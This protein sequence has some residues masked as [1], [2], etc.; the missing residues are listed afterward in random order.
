MRAIA[1]P[2]TH[3]KR[4]HL[5]RRIDECEV[6]APHKISDYDKVT[7]SFERNLSIDN[8]EMDIKHGNISIAF[9]MTMCT[10]GRRLKPRSE[11]K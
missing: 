10:R 11:C 7:M 4:N 5:C 2:E 9:A 1:H 3:R 8:A 6:Q